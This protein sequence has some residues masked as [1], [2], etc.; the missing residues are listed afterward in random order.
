C[1]TSSSIKETVT[2]FDTIDFHIAKAFDPET[3]GEILLMCDQDNRDKLLFSNSTIIHERIRFNND[4]VTHNYD[5]SGEFK[6]WKKF[7]LGFIGNLTLNDD[8]NRPLL[9]ENLT[10]NC[11]VQEIICSNALFTR[12]C[13]QGTPAWVVDN[14]IEE[15]IPLQKSTT[16]QHLSFVSTFHFRPVLKVSGIEVKIGMSNGQLVTGEAQDLL[17]G[18]HEVYLERGQHESSYFLKVASKFSAYRCDLNFS[19]HLH[20]I[21]EID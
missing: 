3:P 21:S 7:R 14:G 13:L 11:T 17:P 16:K 8:K 20:I 6:D 1:I 10:M 4:L 12:Q 15:K 2:I 18:H 5:N 9:P 19:F